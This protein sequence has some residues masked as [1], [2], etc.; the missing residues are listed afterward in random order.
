M[1][2]AADASATGQ[3]MADYGAVMKAFQ[4]QW[5]SM[6]QAIGGPV[7]S[8][9]I[10]VMKQLTTS[11]NEMGQS[12]IAHGTDISAVMKAIE[13]P[14][15]GI[16]DT[17]IVIGPPIA[18]TAQEFVDFGNAVVALQN[19][20]ATTMRSFWKSLGID[21]G[22]DRP[23]QIDF[24]A[25]PGAPRPYDPLSSIH[26]AMA[27]PDPGYAERKRRNDALNPPKPYDPLSS[28]KAPTVNVAAP[29][30]DVKAVNV[31][32]SLDGIVYA[33]AAKIESIVMGAI[34][35]PNSSA[36]SRRTAKPHA[37]GCLQLLAARI[38]RL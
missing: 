26:A 17:L 22:E 23:G 34:H 27:A 5:K 18:K 9:M 7:A 38:A 28:I 12:A 35:L 14:I 36:G 1:S 16:V 15:K 10:P 4:A 20:I 24:N 8:S 31:T 21:T 6:L 11:F 29:Q 30:V 32:A 33:L 37:A 2:E 19:K 3:S 13:E 25:K